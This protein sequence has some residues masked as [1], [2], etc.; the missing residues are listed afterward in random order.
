MSENTFVTSQSW[1]SR[2]GGAIKGIFVGILL[3]IG[4][5]I[6]LWWNE[7]RAVKT[8]KGLEQGQEE[9]INVQGTSPLPENNGKLVYVTGE[10]QTNDTLTDALFGIKENS[11]RLKRNV[12]MYQWSEYSESKKRKKIGGGEETTVTYKYKKV[13]SSSLIN[14]ANFKTAEGHQNPSTKPYASYDNLAENITLGEFNI[15]NSL[16]SG[17]SKYENCEI[18]E[19]DTIAIPNGTILNDGVNSTAFIGNGSY[20]SPMIGDMKVNFQTV[21]K[22]NY[23]IISK[24]LNNTFEPFTTN[25]NTS[26]NMIRTGTVSSESMF[27]SAIKSNKVVTWILR[28]VGFFLVYGGFSMILKPLVIVGDLIPFVGNIV[29]MGTSLVAGIAAFCVALVVIALA[30]IFYRPILG[31]SLLVIGAGA[32]FYLYKRSREKKTPTATT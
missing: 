11:L 12:E 14:S 25:T 26:I 19:L 18:K 4:A 9:V 28:L 17:L 5:M 15:P 21:K 31:I 30:W 32:G 8:A 22:G 3:I 23:S 16:K 7:G 24:Q 27:E 20:G 13:W 2:L 10:I 29:N 1:I 6:L